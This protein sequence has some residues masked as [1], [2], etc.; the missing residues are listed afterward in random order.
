MFRFCNGLDLWIIWMPKW[1]NCVF[2]IFVSIILDWNDISLS[3]QA[4]QSGFLFIFLVISSSQSH[5]FHSYPLPLKV[6]CSIP[7]ILNI[8]VSKMWPLLWFNNNALGKDKIQSFDLTSLIPHD[9]FLFS[10][11]IALRKVIYQIYCEWIPHSYY[12]FLL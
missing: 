8:D 12:L 5:D 1:L 10:W 4:F 7:M 9:F 6:Y 3:V 2:P 11:V